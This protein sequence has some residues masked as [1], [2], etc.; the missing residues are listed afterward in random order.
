[1]SLAEC[2]DG[3]LGVLY[4]QVEGSGWGGARWGGH[5]TSEQAP[6]QWGVRKSSLKGHM[7]LTPIS[8]ETR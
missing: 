1:M 4:A 5:L 7:M 6:K 3:A 2:G 8:L